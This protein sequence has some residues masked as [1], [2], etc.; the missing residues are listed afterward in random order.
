LGI[1]VADLGGNTEIVRRQEALDDAAR[2]RGVSIMPDCGLAPGMANILAAEGMR[3]LDQTDSVRLYV[4]G[5]PQQP[6]PPLNYTVVYS[7]EG[8]LD[9]YTTPSWVL[10]R[11]APA[12]VEALSD[13][14]RVPFPAPVGELEAFHTAGGI[15]TMPWRFAGCVQSMEYKTLRYPGHA[16][17]MRAVR[18]LGLLATQPVD[19]KGTPVVPRDAFMA[20]VSPRLRKP[21]ARDL[22]ALRVEVAGSKDGKPKR[23][24]FLLL[25]Y[26]DV[27]HGISAMMRATGYSL[28]ITGM[29][30]AE[31]Q[32]PPG[33]KPAY[34]VMPF[35]SYVAELR[36]RGIEVREVEDA[37]PPVS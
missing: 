35:G 8:V 29:M 10:R 23:V 32:I 1:H 27:E 9:Y 12:Q 7:L 14:E 34:E 26:Y 15:S 6:E 18:D 13:V 20:V 28:A 11:G 19:V 2:R 22:V 37:T 25:D 4:G 33:A 3:R 5:L 21:N 17:I 31:G 36:K 24:T 16:V 30:Q